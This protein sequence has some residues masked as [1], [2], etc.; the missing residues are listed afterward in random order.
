MTDEKEEQPKAKET[1]KLRRTWSIDLVEEEIRVQPSTSQPDS[2]E[3]LAQ[4]VAD[5]GGEI[6]LTISWADFEKL[7]TTAKVERERFASIE[8]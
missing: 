1:L 3:F 4:D 8:E 2:I 6:L 7:Y 5:D